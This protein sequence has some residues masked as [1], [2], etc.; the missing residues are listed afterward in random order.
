M[1]SNEISV[2]RVL[3]FFTNST[4]KMTVGEVSKRVTFSKSTVRRAMNIFNQWGYVESNWED[5]KST[6]RKVFS[7]TDEG[8][9]ALSE[10]REML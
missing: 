7:I 10:M 4:S 1:S 8:R 2:L 5:Y 6:G 9:I 3:A